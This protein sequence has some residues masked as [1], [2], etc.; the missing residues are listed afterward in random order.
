M[1]HTTSFP[2]RIRSKSHFYAGAGA[3]VTVSYQSLRPLS[4]GQVDLVTS[5]PISPEKQMPIFLIHFGH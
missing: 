4:S 5:N 3:S 2:S 1:P